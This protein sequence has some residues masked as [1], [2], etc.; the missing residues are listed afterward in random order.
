[1]MQ[2]EVP[3]TLTTSPRRTPAPMASQCASNAP[4]G[5]GMP[6]RSP[7]F[8][9]HSGERW[10]AIW[11]EVCVAAG[12]FLAH[13]GEQRIDGG[14]KSSG[15]KPPRRGVPHPLV[16]HGADAARNVGGIVDAA[17]RRRHHVAMLQRGGEAARLS[18]LWRSQWSSFG[19][20]PFGGVDAAAPVD[21]F[22]PLAVRGGGDLGGFFPGAMVA[23]EIVIVE[24][25]QV[26]VDRNDAG[27]GGVERDGFDGRPS[28][29]AFARAGAVASASAR[30]WSAWLCVA[31]SGSSFLRSSGYSA[32]PAPEPSVR[33]IED[34]DADTEGSEIDARYDAH[35]PD[36]RRDDCTLDSLHG[37]RD[38]H[39]DGRPAEVARRRFVNRRPTCARLA[40]T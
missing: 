11:S 33:A 14:Q 8:S 22:E 25:L 29:P 2:V 17:E 32:T 12:Q 40:A 9:A 35:A 6:A 24:R 19:E 39:A 23:P 37:H 4:T 3:T 13:A 38:Q 36:A 15:G 18:G 21:G 16:A 28:M 31:W 27:A 26:R 1:M 10:P 7:S 5:I 30:M 34:G 20:S